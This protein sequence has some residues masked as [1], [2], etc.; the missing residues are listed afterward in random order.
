MNQQN[1]A[2]V[3]VLFSN[4]GKA[5]IVGGTSGSLRVLDSRSYETLQVLSHDGQL[6][7]LLHRILC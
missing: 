7:T 6:F 2:L 5:V 3:P 4:D 1:N